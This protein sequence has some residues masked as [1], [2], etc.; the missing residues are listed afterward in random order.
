MSR[1]DWSRQPCSSSSTP[2]EVRNQRVLVD[3]ADLADHRTLRGPGLAL[4]ELHD[5]AIHADELGEAFRQ[6]AVVTGVEPAGHGIE[7]RDAR[8]ATGLAGVAAAQFLEGDH[9]HPQ[10]RPRDHAPEPARAPIL[11][12]C[13]RRVPDHLRD[14]GARHDE[15]ELVAAGSAGNRSRRWRL[16]ARPASLSPPSS[17]GDARPRGAGAPGRACRD[18]R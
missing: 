16:S 6:H 18:S 17:T 14:A 13:R 8:A 10:R 4:I 11:S 1:C 5:L 2:L 9:R 7:D 3:H 15:A 12:F